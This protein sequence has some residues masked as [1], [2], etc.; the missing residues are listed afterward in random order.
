MLT[1][2]YTATSI[3]GFIADPNNSLDWLFQFED[4]SGSKEQYEEFVGDVGAVVMGST[5]YEWITREVGFLD[6]PSLWPYEQP[7][8]IFSS[9]DLDL[10]AGRD[11][12]L[13]RG[14]VRPVHDQ[15]RQAAG[16]H[17]IWVVGGGD[18]AGQFHDAGLLDEL[19]LTVAPVTLG[20]G[21]PLLPRR[22]ANPP[23][24]L[25]ETQT[26]GA[27]VNLR[28]RVQHPDSARQP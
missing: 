19:I 6:D 12:R 4:A 7:T 24:A 2:F 18:L 26:F 10:P 17:N 1:Q 14:D 22:I 27:F 25:V 8:W 3:D 20:A 9:R 21:A 13:V 23:L 11:V 16:D 5:T 28:Y 15:M